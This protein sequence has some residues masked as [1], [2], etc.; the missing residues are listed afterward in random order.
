MNKEKGNSFF[1][2]LVVYSYILPH[3][4]E[5]NAISSHGK[6]FHHPMA[7]HIC[8]CEAHNQFGTH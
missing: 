4:I 5:L 1:S 2:H 3:T 6:D 7:H 8:K